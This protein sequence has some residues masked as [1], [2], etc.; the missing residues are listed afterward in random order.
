MD[1]L[2][3]EFKLMCASPDA[4]HLDKYSDIMM[5]LELSFLM[6]CT[7]FRDGLT[8]FFGLHAQSSQAGQWLPSRLFSVFDLK[9]DGKVEVGC[10]NAL[11]SALGILHSLMVFLF[12]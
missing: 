7:L 2:R 4:T 11:S 3:V 1:Q 6:A 8:S 12:S 5:A 9:K 10:H